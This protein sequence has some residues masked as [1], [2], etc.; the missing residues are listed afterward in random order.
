VASF[1]REENVDSDN[2]LKIFDVLN[3]IATLYQKPIVVSTHP[4]TAKKIKEGQIKID[5]RVM[6]CK[7]F[8][9]PDYV[10]LQKNSMAVLSDSGTI[11]EESSILNFPSLNIRSSHERPE[12]MEEAVTI[13]TGINK[14]IILSSLD[15][16]L[17]R[18]KCDSNIVKDYNYNNVSEKVLGIILSY[19]DYVNK[20][21][22]FKEGE[23][24]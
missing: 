24:A 6:L 17:C 2:I 21:V 5:E 12:G 16:I 14:K 11:T 23:D 4:R 18:Q 8:G 15:I 3:E 19:I 22:W 13:M 7:P 9:F 1:H 20:K 10:F